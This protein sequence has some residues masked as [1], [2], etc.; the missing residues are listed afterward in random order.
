MKRVDV[1]IIGAGSAGLGAAQA[2]QAAG[3]CPVF[4]VPGPAGH[5]PT[6][7]EIVR[8]MPSGTRKILTPAHA[9]L[10]GMPKNRGTIR[11]RPKGML[12]GTHKLWFRFRARGSVLKTE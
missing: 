9:L 11:E 8:E 1:V 10:T 3:L 12:A 6:R 2:L 7:G 5:H 4:S